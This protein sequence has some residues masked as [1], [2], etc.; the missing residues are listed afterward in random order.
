MAKVRGLLLAGLLGMLL[1]W[2]APAQAAVV[3]TAGAP[4]AAQV[5]G[6]IA[7]AEALLPAP[8]QT[9][10]GPVLDPTQ[11][12]KANAEKS[13]NKLIAGGIAVVLLA[14]VFFGRRARSKRN[15]GD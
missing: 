1:L 4:A 14:I 7:P 6:V 10:P 11:T 13:R 2:A 9:Q 5:A 8:R 15:K 3:E 12:D